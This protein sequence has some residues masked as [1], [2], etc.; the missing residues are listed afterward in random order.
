MIDEKLD[1]IEEKIRNASSMQAENKSIVLD[2]L[3]DLKKELK[4]VDEKDTALLSNTGSFAEVGA[5]EVARENGDKG[6]LD[7]A[8]QGLNES[9]KGF[10]KS[11]PKLVQVINSIC[12]QLSNSGL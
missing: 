9:V 7:I 5:N 2:L 11:H 12:T 8:L 6:I 10:E 1:K 4:E 3:S